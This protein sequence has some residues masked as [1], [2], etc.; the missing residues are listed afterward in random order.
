MKT[1]IGLLVALILACA[2]ALIPIA[3]SAG[4]AVSAELD[5]FNVKPGGTYQAMLQ[6]KNTGTD[7]ADFDVFYQAAGF[8]PV[9][10]APK[11]GSA[12]GFINIGDQAQKWV[13]ISTVDPGNTFTVTVGAG[14]IVDVPVVLAIPAGV[15]LPAKWGFWITVQPDG[16]G[17]LVYDSC[18]TCL[19]SQHSSNNLPLV[20]GGVFVVGL[21]VL[22]LVLRGGDKSDK[23]R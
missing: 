20:I 12:A 16:G 17:N 10:Q 18:S 5:F 15:T 22:V 8:A 23:K 21:I 4:A 11:T 7:T 19:V 13:K 14:K 2:C 1:K 9:G 3:V 6:V